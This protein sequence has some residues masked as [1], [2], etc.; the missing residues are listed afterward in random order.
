LSYQQKTKCDWGVVDWAKS[1]TALSLELGVSNERVRQMRI[2]L[3]QP[4]SPNKNKR[5][6]ETGRERALKFY[7]PKLTIAEIADRAG[8]SRGIA[9]SALCGRERKNG[10]R[11]YEW[12]AVDWTKLNIE[13]AAETGAHVVRVTHARQRFA[14]QHLKRSPYFG[15]RGSA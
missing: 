14:P 3:K 1:D 9:A 11:K 6:A 4:E 12:E 2:K 5:V 15:A 10:N 8:V 13:I 7:S